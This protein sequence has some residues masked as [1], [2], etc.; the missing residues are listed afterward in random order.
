MAF[1]INAHKSPYAECHYAES[2]ILFIVMFS[3]VMLSVVMLSVVMLSVVAP[4]RGRFLE[5]NLML[6]PRF[7]CDQ[8]Y[9]CL[10]YNFGHI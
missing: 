7:R 6:T 8:I 10:R 4:S 5:E 1:S 2:R 9:K 3:V